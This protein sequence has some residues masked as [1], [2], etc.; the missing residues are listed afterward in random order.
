MPKIDRKLYNIFENSINQNS[1]SGSKVSEEE[2][3]LLINR[4]HRITEKTPLNCLCPPEAKEGSKHLRRLLRV[5]PES[6]T[7]EGKIIIQQYMLTG[8]KHIYHHYRDT[9][10]HLNQNL[11]NLEDNIVVHPSKRRHRI[12]MDTNAPIEGE[13][14]SERRDSRRIRSTED[15]GTIT[16]SIENHSRHLTE[17]RDNISSRSNNEN[18]ENSIPNIIVTESPSEHVDVSSTVIEPEIRTENINHSVNLNTENIGD[19]LHVESSNQPLVD[20]VYGKQILNFMAKKKTEPFHWFPM[21]ETKPGGDTVN[22]LYTI[23]GPLDKLD[24]I[25]EGKA[26][27]YEYNNLRQ[28]FGSGRRWWGHCNNASEAGCLLKAPRH[29][30]EMVAKDGSTI[31]LTKNDIE[32]LIVKVVPCLVAKTDFK[33]ERNNGRGASEEPAPATFINIMKDWAKDGLPFVMDIDPE[34]QVWNFPYDQVKIYESN[35]A[36]EGS[37]VDIPG[38]TKF[39]HIEME[40]TGYK[41]KARVYECYVKY[42]NNDKVIHSGWIKTPNSNNNPDF[43][44]RPHPKGDLMD[45]SLWVLNS[46]ATNPEVDPQLVYD[47][48]MKSLA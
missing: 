47:I 5:Y 13:I 26:R 33:G 38:K 20:S 45:K 18:V 25:N 17:S 23:G 28:P 46:R 9:E 1:K 42:G 16:R 19:G 40:G 22:N 29:G 15:E 8:K 34:S 48:Y 30:V 27:L 11:N 2:A 14:H 43:M 10:R 41:N 6:F 31:K 36:P 35:K 39:Y 37:N 12:K 7:P 24:R 4:A 32:G 44:W 21:E 3:M